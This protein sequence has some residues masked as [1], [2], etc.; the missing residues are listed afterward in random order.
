MA[1]I[2]KILILSVTFLIAVAFVCGVIYVN[3]IAQRI[4]KMK[5]MGVRITATASLGENLK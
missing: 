5:H 3:A 4:L 2:F 1:E